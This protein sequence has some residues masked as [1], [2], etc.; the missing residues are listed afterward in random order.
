MCMR[1]VCAVLCLGNV[2][3]TSPWNATAAPSDAP[4]RLRA[5][6]EGS[7]TPTF[8]A[9]SPRTS[10]P[11]EIPSPRGS[12]INRFRG[13]SISSSPGNF[14]FSRVRAEPAA[15]AAVL[16]NPND[17][18]R[19]AET[20]LRSLWD[21]VRDWNT[22]V[23]SGSVHEEI[24][25]ELSRRFEIVYSLVSFNAT[26]SQELLE[27]EES[28]KLALEPP[29]SARDLR[30]GMSPGINLY[31]ELLIREINKSIHE[32]PLS[33][34]SS[35]SIDESAEGSG[36]DESSVESGNDDDGLHFSLDE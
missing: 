9:G 8:F 27:V 12:P 23:I 18:L 29:K 17:A 35:P 3:A 28:I 14:V 2:L 1:I 4:P 30:R 15:S 21:Q 33:T 11:I 10:L 19:L 6:S 31:F 7:E 13:S 26:L 20:E 16:M 24:V 34:T 5:P 22:Q 32:E 25:S 36:S